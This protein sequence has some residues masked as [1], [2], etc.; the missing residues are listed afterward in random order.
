MLISPKPVWMSQKSCH[1]CKRERNCK[2]VNGK[3]IKQI[4]LLQV[5]ANTKSLEVGDDDKE[6]C[7][8]AHDDDDVDNYNDDANEQKKDEYNLIM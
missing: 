1:Y 3:E 6:E 8:A 2:L 4:C 5:N 7:S